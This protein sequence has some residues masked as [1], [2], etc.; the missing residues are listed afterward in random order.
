MDIVGPV[1]D[2]SAECEG[3]LRSLP[4][5]FGIEA[6]LLM[7][8]ADTQRL[9]T[10]VAAEGERVVGF[11]TLE[12]HFP[13][14]WEVHCIAVHREAR[15]RG[16]GR[17]LLTHVEHWLLERGATLLQVK[18]IAATTVD[19]AY[20]QTREFYARAGFVPL[21]VFPQ[22]WSPNNPCLQL[23]KVVRRDG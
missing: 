18:T 21:E 3:I 10:F 2:I 1:S 7:Y 12:Q 5:W 14:S 11:L 17:A 4:E 16:V 23:V 13:T 9:P 22:L 6:S 15:H 19:A 20:A 8:V